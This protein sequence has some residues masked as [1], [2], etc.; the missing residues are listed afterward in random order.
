MN[1]D[2]SLT[3][4]YLFTNKIYNDEV[5]LIYQAMISCDLTNYTDNNIEFILCTYFSNN[6]KAEVSV[7][8][9]DLVLQK[10]KE[11]DN[12]PEEWE[13]NDPF[14]K[15]VYFKD[16]SKFIL[17]C[18]KKNLMRFRYFEY[19][20]DDNEIYDKLSQVNGITES[21]LNIDFTQNDGVFPYNDIMVLNPVTII[22]V[23]AK[24][25][26]YFIITI[27]RFYDYDTSMSIKIYHTFISDGFISIFCPRLAKTLDSF[28]ISL[29][30]I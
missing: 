27:I 19:N 16:S 8:D 12:E 25:M 17:A 10:T 2:S 26:D 7:F 22:K 11:L 6:K 29:S 28:I 20:K 24:D 15:I 13:N 30:A 23:F 18:R 5:H 9:Q 1:F 14:I 3:S 21:Y 4:S